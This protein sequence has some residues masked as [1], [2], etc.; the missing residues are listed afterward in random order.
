MPIY[1]QTEHGN[2]RIPTEGENKLG[3]TNWDYFQLGH[4]LKEVDYIVVLGSNDMLPAQFGA[5]LFLKGLSTGK[6][7]ICA[8]GAGGRF[9]DDSPKEIKRAGMTEAEQLAAIAVKYG[10]AE[11]QILLEKESKHTRANVINT[12]EMLASMGLE[13]PKRIMSVHMP[14]AER[15]DYGTWKAV[16][17]DIEVVVT[18]PRVSYE[19]YHKTGFQGQFDHYR[20]IDTLVGNIHRTILVYPK[21]GDMIKQ[22]ITPEARDAYHGLIDA[23]YRSELEGKNLDYIRIPD[24]LVGDDRELLSK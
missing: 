2:V 4:E 16:A 15:R 8:G 1:K 22:L 9:Y 5:E 24:E 6:K 17:R 11:D 23:G 20:I 13:R 3:K 7:L 18:S 21:K 12:L 10:V 14:S 19:D